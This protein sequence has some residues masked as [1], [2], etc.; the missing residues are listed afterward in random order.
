MKNMS[1]Y[2]YCMYIYVHFTYTN[3]KYVYINLLEYFLMLFR[4]LNI[5]YMYL[6]ADMRKMWKIIFLYIL[7]HIWHL[8]SLYSHP[9]VSSISVTKL[10]P[11]IFSFVFN[12]MIVILIIISMN[13]KYCNILFNIFNMIDH[14]I[15]WIVLVAVIIIILSQLRC[16]KIQPNN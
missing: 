9:F 13:H 15:D 14:F 3:H 7:N 5:S 8:W 1:A 6:Q 12:S 4:H 11:R 2:V 16:V 10:F